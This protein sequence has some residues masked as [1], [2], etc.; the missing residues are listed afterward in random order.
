[1]SITV[2]KTDAICH[3]RI[4]GEATIYTVEELYHAICQA[5]ADCTVLEMNL[6]EV[7][8]MD[9]AGFQQLLLASREA[10]RHGITLRLVQPSAATQEVLDLYQMA[11]AFAPATVGFT[12]GTV[13][14]DSNLQSAMSVHP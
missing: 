3:L 8:E 1:M 7:S 6:A 13:G 9:T 2:E 12:A 4:M 10:R 14:P 11:A 5:L